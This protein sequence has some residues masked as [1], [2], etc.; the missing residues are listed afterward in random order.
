MVT[1]ILVSCV[2]LAKLSIFYKTF[3]VKIDTTLKR[4]IHSPDPELGALKHNITIGFEL[5]NILKNALSVQNEM[6]APTDNGI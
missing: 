5:N 2:L 6:I 1:A 3:K 4:V